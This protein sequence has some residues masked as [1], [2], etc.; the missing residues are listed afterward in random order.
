[1][2]TLRSVVAT[3]VLAVLGS[4][5][6]GCSSDIFDLP[7]ALEAQSYAF[8]FGKTQGTIP[9]VACDPAAPGV[10]GSA[11]SVVVDPTLGVPANVE[12]SLGCDAA[13]RH[14]FAQAAARVAQPMVV[15]AGDLARETIS[16]VRFADIAYTV[17]A[18]SLTFTVPS[19]DIYAGPAGSQRETDPG[20]ALVGTTKSVPAAT[21]ITTQQHLIVDDHTPAR[22][23]IED[24]IRNAEEI[25]FIVV[26]MPRIDAGGAIPA[27]VIRVDVYPIVVV[28]FLD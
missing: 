20:V 3:F 24:A 7:V 14:C 6:A 17:P 4:V 2:G 28:N 12:I 16:Y 13:S 11:P 22:P 26:V 19:I 1:M 27:G 21:T 9:T 10:C 23:L 5:G 18:N 15:Q 8:D 25:A